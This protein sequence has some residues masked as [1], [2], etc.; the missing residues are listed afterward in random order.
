MKRF[1]AMA[2]LLLSMPFAFAAPDAAPKY[3]EGTHYVRLA[4]PVR[5]SDPA[6]IEVMEVFW[7]GCPHCF[8][9]EPLINDWK[10]TLKP[11]VNF[12]RSPAMWNQM[13]A[14]HAQAFYA[15]QSLGVL[16]SINRDIAAGLRGR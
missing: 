14:V 11:D 6:R 12:Q 5:T 9:L 2:A 4:Q 8:H 16:V 7:Y 1:F 13:M 10:K 3:V 15:A